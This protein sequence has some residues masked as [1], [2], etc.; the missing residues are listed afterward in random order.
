MKQCIHCGTLSQDTET[1]CR[2]CGA[3]LL[4]TPTVQQPCPPQY[5]QTMQS[6]P[7]AQPPQ[8]MP[9]APPQPIA[10]RRTTPFTW[11]DICTI[12]GFVS[13]IIGYFW[14]SVLLLPLGLIASIIGFRGD[15][16]RGLAVAGIVLA[17]IGLLI[18]LAFILYEAA[19]LPDWF[20]NGVWN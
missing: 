5:G 1:I 12:F 2:Q 20:T 17:S 10:F 4:E 15:R 7:P 11:A 8:W 16:T 9:Q 18:K 3:S 6:M 13:S 19:F 14:G